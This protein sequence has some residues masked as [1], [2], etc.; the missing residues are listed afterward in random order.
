M[1]RKKI[2]K[3]TKFQA[4]RSSCL[5]WDAE[6]KTAAQAACRR[7]H[8]DLVPSRGI[9]VWTLTE[10]TS[11]CFVAWSITSVP[12]SC[13]GNPARLGSILDS[14]YISAIQLKL[15][16]MGHRSSQHWG[17]DL[18]V[19]SQLHIK[20]WQ[21]SARKANIQVLR[22]MKGFLGTAFKAI[23]ICLTISVE[24]EVETIVQ[25]L[26]KTSALLSAI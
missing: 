14:L 17:L 24:N 1:G 25:F 16:Q 8:L 2:N 4:L 5:F 13:R 10:L 18:F 12:S 21:F 20:H 15:L 26:M 19:S 7:P 11:I 9:Q 3:P 23:K 6:S 22:K